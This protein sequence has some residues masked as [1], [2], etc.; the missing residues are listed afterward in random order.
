MV[1]TKNTLQVAVAEKDIAD[2]VW[3][4]YHRFF[5]R[6]NTNAADV[7][8]AACT[9]ISLPAICAVDVALARAITAITELIHCIVGAFWFGQ[10]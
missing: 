8:T 10:K 2:S 5:S 6:V 9:A 4:A 1:L 3:P 7:K